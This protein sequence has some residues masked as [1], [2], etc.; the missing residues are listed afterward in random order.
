MANMMKIA[1]PVLAIGGAALTGG[2]S[3]G[4]LGADAAGTGLTGALTSGLMD[5]GA[6]ASVVQASTYL[7]AAAPSLRLASMGLQGIGTVAQAIGA[8]NAGEEEKSA[9]TQI[10]NQERQQANNVEGAAENEMQQENLKTA[11]IL[12]GVRAAAAGQSGSAT[13]PSTVTTMQTIA[14]QGQ[15]RALNTLYSGQSEAQGLMNKATAATYSGDLAARE[16]NAK[17]IGSI[18]QGGSSLFN[19]YGSVDTTKKDAYGNQLL[20]WQVQQ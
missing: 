10:A 2:A 14:G 3:L 15:L 4:L 19:T 9:E 12:S 16:G 1:L 20:P 8:H 17:A 11:Y 7:G 13:D 5:I 6:P 18:L